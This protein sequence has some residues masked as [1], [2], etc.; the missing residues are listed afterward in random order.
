[1][2][3][4]VCLC[5]STR[6]MDHF[7]EAGWKFTLD[8]EIV[9]SVG[10]AKHVETPDGGHVGEALGP[11]VCERLDELHFRKIDLADRV[12]VLNVEGYI[13]RST[14]REIAYAVAKGKEIGFLEQQLGDDF[15]DR[16]SQTLG[17]MA[18][19]FSMGQ[20]PALPETLIAVN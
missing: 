12:Y 17:K 9:L 18:A 10:V 8:G 3:K 2:A 11:D 20:T 19:E 13:G 14:A 15:L 1:M 4:I 7:H 5:G 6:F 16:N